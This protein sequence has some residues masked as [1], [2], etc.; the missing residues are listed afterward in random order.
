M[1]AHMK[2]MTQGV[3]K[4]VGF[5]LVFAASTTWA[6]D[7][8]RVRGTID[9]IDGPIYVV[10]AVNGDELKV[11]LGDN[12]SIVG[13]VKASLSD[14][15]PG[16][17]VGV[18]GMQQPDGSQEAIEVHISPESQRGSGEGHYPWDL[19][20][21]ST[22]TNANVEQIVPG[23]NGQTMTVRY[24]DGEKKILVPANAPIVSI[25]PGDKSELKPG[26]KI[27]IFAAKKLPDG[28]L[29]APSVR[30]GRDGL[31]PPM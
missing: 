23:V 11:I 1:E 14:L 13:V 21:Q 29:M 30:V 6:Q 5:A 9:R 12:A 10:K 18:A 2:T 7:T 16:S 8:V 22:M 17:F 31:M 27:Y 4:V 20:P 15:K 19:R 25:V 3:V 28:T 24:K 26:S